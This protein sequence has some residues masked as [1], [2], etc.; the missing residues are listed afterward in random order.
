MQIKFVIDNL[1][2]KFRFQLGSITRASKVDFD[3]LQN[4]IEK[5]ETDCKASWD[6]LKAIA[7]HD[8]PTQIKLK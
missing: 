5:M 3:E 1:T 4:T 7:K 8:G 2:K 6:H